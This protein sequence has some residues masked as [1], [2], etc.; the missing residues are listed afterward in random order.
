MRA[1]LIG[2]VIAAVVIGAFVVG[3]MRGDEPSG[4]FQQIGEQIDEGLNDAGR[5]IEDATD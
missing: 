1:A 2:A 3:Q 5:E 4:Q